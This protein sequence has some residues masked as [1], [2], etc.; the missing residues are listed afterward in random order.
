MCA[1]LHG[2]APAAV[3]LVAL[4]LHGCIDRLILDHFWQPVPLT[5]AAQCSRSILCCV[6]YCFIL[7]NFTYSCSTFS[8]MNSMCKTCLGVLSSSTAMRSTATASSLLLLTKSMQLGR[9]ISTVTMRSAKTS[10]TAGHIRWCPTCSARWGSHRYG[11]CA[12]L[13]TKRISVHGPACSGYMAAPWQG[14]TVRD[15]TLILRHIFLSV[16]RHVGNG[17]IF[18]WARMCC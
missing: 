13:C 18:T 2:L 15:R 5:D 11:T 8:K 16:I 17:T 3:E 12:P 6:F 9:P 10:F 7:F 1:A 4:P 14:L